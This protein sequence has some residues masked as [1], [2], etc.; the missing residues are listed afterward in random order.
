MVSP[1]VRRLINSANSLKRWA[2][3][4]DRTAATAPAREAMWRRFE[5]Q[6]DPDGKLTPEER[7][8]RADALRRAHLRRMSARSAQVRAERKRKRLDA[9]KKA[10]DAAAAAAAA[11]T[12]STGDTGDQS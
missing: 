6:A 12:A 10:R 7:A 11:R 4:P 1:A 2:Q 5:Q 8:K 3:E 9:E